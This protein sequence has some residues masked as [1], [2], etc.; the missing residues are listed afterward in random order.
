MDPASAAQDFRGTAAMPARRFAETAFCWP[1]LA[2]METT[3][4]AT[5]ALP[6]AAS[7]NSSNALMALLQILLSAFISK[8]TSPC[9]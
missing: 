9:P 1:F 3:R 6:P 2:T 8:R 5:D 4:T 7:K